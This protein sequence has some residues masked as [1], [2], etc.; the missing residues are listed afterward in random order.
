MK[1][2]V[3]QVSRT[4][5]FLCADGPWGGGQGEKRPALHLRRLL[6]QDQQGGRDAGPQVGAT[7]NVELLYLHNYDLFFFVVLFSNKAFWWYFSA[8]PLSFC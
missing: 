7:A 8:I 2:L 1:I 4:A 6:G 3:Q 5:G